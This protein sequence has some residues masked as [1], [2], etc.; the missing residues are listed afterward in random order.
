VF[1]AHDAPRCSPLRSTTPEARRLAQSVPGRCIAV[2]QPPDP[3]HGRSSVEAYAGTRACLRECS[4]AAAEE[5][6]APYGAASSSRRHLLSGLRGT[7]IADVRRHDGLAR[8]VRSAPRLSG[9]RDPSSGAGQS[10]RDPRAGWPQILKAP[11]GVSVQ[12]PA[13]GP[14]TRL[15]H[16]APLARGRRLLAVVGSAD[17]ECAR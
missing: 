14:A 17:R 7:K 10:G 4:P 8:F 6:S 2:T 9:I 12:S 16:S 1:A 11:K 15:R 5:P 3:F 13:I